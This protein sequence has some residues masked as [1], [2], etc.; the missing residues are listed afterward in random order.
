LLEAMLI[1]WPGTLLLVSH[2]R[3]F[4]DNVVTSTIVFEGDGRVREY[5]GGYEDWLRQR[6]AASAGL[7][8]ASGEPKGSPLRKVVEA[9]LQV[10]LRENVEADLQVRLRPRKA[11]YREQQ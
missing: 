3:A 11:S 6:P 10:R 4:I 5:V 8:A 1:D 7:G 2:D 9:D